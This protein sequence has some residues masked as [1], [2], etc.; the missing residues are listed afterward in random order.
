MPTVTA[1][2]TIIVLRE[3]FAR[4]GSPQQLLSDDGPNFFLVFE[5][6]QC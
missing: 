4:Y 1:N 2:K 3:I 5:V 6:K